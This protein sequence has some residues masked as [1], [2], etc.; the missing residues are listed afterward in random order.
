LNYTVAEFEK[1]P[2]SAGRYE[3]LDGQLVEKP[4][5]DARHAYISRLLIRSYDFF[6]P[7]EQVGRLW[8]E[9]NMRL[10]T[11][12]EPIPDLSFWKAENIFEVKGGSGTTPDLATSPD[13][14]SSGLSLRT[15]LGKHHLL[16][17]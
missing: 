8:H 13:A 11:G 7:N 12:N 9:L 14:S 6:D 17:I 3:L 4:V 15:I 16:N 5:P 2:E 1:M 10:D